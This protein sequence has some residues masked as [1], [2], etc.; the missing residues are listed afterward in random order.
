[1]VCYVTV[2][3]R[4]GWVICLVLLMWFNKA[5]SLAL[6]LLL[7]LTMQVIFTTSNRDLC[8]KSMK[9][10][11]I[12]CWFKRKQGVVPKGKQGEVDAHDLYF[13]IK[14]IWI[15]VDINQACQQGSADASPWGCA[16]SFQR[17]N[18]VSVP[19]QPAIQQAACIKIVPRKISTWI[20]R[21]SWCEQRGKW[22]WS[23]LQSLHSGF[24]DGNFADTDHKNGKMQYTDKAVIPPK[25]FRNAATY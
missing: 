13:T 20:L 22:A 23:D 3:I 17:R 21:N 4:L 16:L 10:V 5:T 6:L 11:Q 9:V 18:V 2:N 7:L 14:Q 15:R 8:N 1:M 19:A 24:Q 25:V 12:F